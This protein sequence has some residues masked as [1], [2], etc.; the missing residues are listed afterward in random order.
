[1]FIIY[2]LVHVI[3]LG[4]SIHEL[5]FMLVE[6]AFEVVGHA[7]VHD[8]I[9]PIGEDVDVEVV[10]SHQ[11]SQ[12]LSFRASSRTYVREPAR[13]LFASLAKI[14]P[15]LLPRFTRSSARRN[16]KAGISKKSALA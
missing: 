13:N 2:Q 6:T 3:F 7:D 14:S 5:V 8:F 1:M 12:S 10:V 15:R 11:T 9:V 4:K 16:D